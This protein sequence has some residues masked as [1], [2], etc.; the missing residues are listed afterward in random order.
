[1]TDERRPG[2]TARRGYRDWRSGLVGIAMVI[3]AGAV[4]TNVPDFGP[5][6]V[7]VAG[8]SFLVMRFAGIRRR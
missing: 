7:V 3:A 5:P 1:M 8:V 4:W 6:I 2:P